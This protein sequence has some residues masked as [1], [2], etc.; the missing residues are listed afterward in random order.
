MSMQAMFRKG[1]DAVD[2]IGS[3]Y[4][5]SGAMRLHGKLGDCG[6]KPATHRPQTVYW[7]WTV[8]TDRGSLTFSS[9]K[10]FIHAYGTKKTKKHTQG[11]WL[12]KEAIL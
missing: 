4:Y 9:A 5:I 2:R 10:N 1:G 7:A 12:A 6:R 3:P 8:I 11:D